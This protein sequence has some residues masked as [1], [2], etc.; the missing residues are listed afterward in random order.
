[1]ASFQ[2]RYRPTTRVASSARPPREHSPAR[3]PAPASPPSTTPTPLPD[4]RRR[5]RQARDRLADSKALSAA[6]DLFRA[7]KYKEARDAFDKLE[8]SNPDDA[9]V[10]Y[11]A[12]LSY[13]FSTKD[14]TDGAVR[15][16]EK[17]IAREEAG[18][19]RT[20]EIDAEFKDLT[21]PNGKD[22]LSAYR[23]PGGQ[24]EEVVTASPA[25]SGSLACLLNRSVGRS[26][27]VS[28]SPIF[29]EGRNL[30]N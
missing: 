13:G 11:Y 8:I 24:R 4:T 28:S 10:W 6:A 19:P 29:A 15:L 9:R 12:A 21:P 17:G 30:P 3:R 1:M 27:A 14:W 22:W 18:T 5:A 25:R 20:A 23:K 16:V 26:S 2:S 7:G